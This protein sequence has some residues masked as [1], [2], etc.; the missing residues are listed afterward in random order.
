MPIINSSLIE[1]TGEVIQ[2]DVRG[3]QF[4]IALKE[5]LSIAVAYS[6]DEEALVI[7]ALRDHNRARLFLRGRGRMT[8][9]GTIERIDEVEEMKVIPRENP[10]SEGPARS[11]GNVLEELGKQV[12]SEEWAKLPADLTDN[13]DWYLYGSTDR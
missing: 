6:D 2:A 13:L 7:E 4:Q 1:I 3:K 11:I 10:Q 12:S 5:G 8:P 9:Q